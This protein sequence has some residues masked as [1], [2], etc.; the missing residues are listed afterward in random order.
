[1]DNDVK[2]THTPNIIFILTDDQ[3]WSGTSARMDERV[4][5]SGSDYYLTPNIERLAASGVR[6]SNGYASASV[7]SPTRYSIQFG[8]TPA[9]LRM[10][11]VNSA[12][13]QR[14]DHDQ[15]SIPKMVT[16]ADPRYATAHFGKWHIECEPAQVGYLVS[17]GRTT[18]DEG[19]M[20]KGPARWS[21]RT[22]PDPKQ[23]S[24]L[25][26]R[27]MHFIEEQTAADRPFYVQLSHYAVHADIV[28]KLATLEKFQSLP[29]GKHHKVAAYAAM[30]EDLDTGIGLLLDK[31]HSLGIASNTFIFLMS[32]NGAVPVIP[33]GQ[34]YQQGQNFPLQRGKWDLTEGGIRIPFMVSGPGIPPGSQCDAPVAAWDLLPTFADLTGY[35]ENLSPY[36]DGV[37]IRPLLEKPESGSIR[38]SHPLVFY[39]PH[40]LGSGLRRPQSAIRD[41]EWKLFK[42]LD[43]GE[44]Y[45][46]SVSEDVS[47]THDV[48]SREPE[49]AR[50]MDAALTT[51]LELV[52]AETVES[53]AKFD[54]PA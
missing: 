27:A 6:F 2:T 52:R 30:T 40:R 1:M 46:Y 4:P 21:P 28:S 17:D 15:F 45:L 7:C 10:T 29:T 3:G 54:D 13:G 38:R 12:M 37:S 31:V 48:S 11:R 49:R 35:R 39:Q 33:P 50:E 8:Q 5:E 42:F 22:A 9:R 14:V 34:P 23:I 32:D 53:A 16:S 47:E 18:N 24:D 26:T 41:N 36:L 25:T 19:G 44:L 43:T 51:Y 20:G